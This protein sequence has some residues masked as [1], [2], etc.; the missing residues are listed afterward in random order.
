M[1]LKGV[2]LDAKLNTLAPVR[3][4]WQT[5]DMV[6]Q[7]ADDREGR[8]R[9]IDAFPDV[10]L[11]GVCLLLFERHV[12]VCP[13]HGEVARG[14]KKQYTI[15]PVGRKVFAKSVPFGTSAGPLSVTW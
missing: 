11:L 6:A 9:K 5:R 3:T 15:E 2:K 7:S 12:R 1:P 13:S 4:L 14:T 8:F 10:G